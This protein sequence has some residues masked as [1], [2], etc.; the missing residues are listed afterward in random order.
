MDRFPKKERPNI[1][2]PEFLAE[3]LGLTADAF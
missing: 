3:I 1:E 2:S